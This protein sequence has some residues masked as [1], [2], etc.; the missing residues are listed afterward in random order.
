VST[1]GAVAAAE[2]R[3]WGYL[4]E[5]LAG[6]GLDRTWV[7][8]VFADPRFEPFTG[9][10]FGLAP[11]EPRSLYRGFL[12][13][14]SIASARRCKVEHRGDL[15]AAERQ[16]GVPSGLLT[17]IIYV[18]TS[19]GRN[20]GKNL[21][22]PRLARLAM[23]N[24]PANLAGNL[25]RLAAQSTRGRDVAAARAVRERAHYLEATFYPEVR[26][27]FQ[28]A[29]RLHV[30]P[31]SIRGSGSGAFGIPQFLPTSYLRFAVDGNGNGTVSL[32]EPADAIASCANY[33]R[34]HG[35]HE[36]LSLRSQRQVIWTYNHSPV[37]IDVVLAL[38]S[39]V[40]RPASEPRRA[41]T[42][43]TQA[44]S[45]GKSVPRS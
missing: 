10:P 44:R 17:A 34:S 4:I 41:G 5:R 19:C 42:V 36:G 33:L 14:S 6:D 35:W 29:E 28:L 25:A 31:L 40:D 37:Y 8:T 30:D 43:K 12:K 3:G 27:A 39:R 21:I 7:A 26:S 24:E 2:Q 45:S 1:A 22:L 11:R 20:T 16:Y 13:S 18:E 38:A 23:A 32:Y 9:L 15:L